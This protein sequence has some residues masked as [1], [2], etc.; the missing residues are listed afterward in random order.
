M[1]NRK[2]GTDFE[3]EL[4][5]LLYSHGYWT[6]NLAQNRAGQPADIIAAKKGVAYLIDAKVCTGKGFDMRRIEENQ[7]NAMVMW[8]NCGNGHGWFAMKVADEVY[9]F[10]LMALQAYRLNQKCLSLDDIRE[11]GM[12]FERWVERCG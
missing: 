6:H 5:D 11:R 10:S 3:N 7:E 4:C 2:L 8:T 12:P 9:M 1:S